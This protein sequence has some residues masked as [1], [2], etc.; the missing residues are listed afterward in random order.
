MTS[1]SKP[2]QIYSSTQMQGRI[3]DIE[4]CERHT[5]NLKTKILDLKQFENPIYEIRC[6]SE[7]TKRMKREKVTMKKRGPKLLSRTKS[8]TSM[9]ERKYSRN[10][11]EPQL[12]G[13]EDKS[14]QGQSLIVRYLQKTSDSGSSVDQKKMVDN[15]IQESINP[16]HYEEYWSNI[17]KNTKLRY[18]VIYKRGKE[19]A[20]STSECHKESGSK[21]VINSDSKS[22]MWNQASTCPDSEFNTEDIA[23]LYDTVGDEDIQR[24]R[25]IEID[26]VTDSD[27]KREV[28]H[29]LTLS[30][31]FQP[32]SEVSSSNDEIISDSSPEI[33][34][35][36]LDLD[37]VFK[38]NMH[39]R[40][41]R[42]PESRYS[43]HHSDLEAVS[44]H[45]DI[46]SDIGKQMLNKE[47]V[48]NI[49][50][51]FS[52]TSSVLTND[53][54]EDP[55]NI[56]GGVNGILPCNKGP[57]KRNRSA[58]MAEDILHCE[59]SN[60]IGKISQRSDG[61]NS[62]QS[63]RS[64]IS[65]LYSTANSQWNIKNTPDHVLS[66]RGSPKHDVNPLYL[67]S[68]LKVRRSLALNYY[69]NTEKGHVIQK[70]G[71]ADCE[72]SPETQVED[73]DNE[74][75]GFDRTISLVEI[76]RLIPPH[77]ALNT[78]EKND[79]EDKKDHSVLQVRSS[80]EV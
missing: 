65:S 16:S 35:L 31:A 33:S 46:R 67:S 32:D 10:K 49:E 76:I 8:M 56:T 79:L 50:V 38:E 72:N 17:I 68:V 36:E 41:S 34:E 60:K 80:Q 75:D 22:G 40:N 27:E 9:M 5:K 25:I 20:R 51:P 54:E 59:S 2:L 1:D 6:T 37:L 21:L 78:N 52:Y 15:S 64:D 14:A 26:T 28:P 77:R 30:Q 12:H 45:I 58:S 55:L 3:D 47:F 71:E 70:I 29:I 62:S 48:R 18:P 19:Q 7:Q 63:Q 61:P 73:S 11:V 44:E 13:I 57:T 24:D 53:C 69:V 42:S 74:V 66:F 23:L 39:I 4:K 43:F